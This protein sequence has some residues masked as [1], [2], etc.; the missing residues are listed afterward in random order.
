LPGWKR[1]WPR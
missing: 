1:F